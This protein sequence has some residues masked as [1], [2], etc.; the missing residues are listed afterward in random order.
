MKTNLNY[1]AVQ[2]LE[3]LAS[4]VDA[5]LP[6]LRALKVMH[7][8]TND[9]V[10][11]LQLNSIEKGSTYSE[12]LEKHPFSGL[13][14]QQNELLCILIKAGELGGVIEVVL[15]RAVEYLNKERTSQQAQFLDIL[16]LLI[17]RGVPILRS[18]SSLPEYTP[19]FA[20]LKKA[21]HD[22]VR[23]GE[24][25]TRPFK[26]SGMYPAYAIALLDV[27]EQTGCLPEMLRRLSDLM[28]KIQPKQSWLHRLWNKLTT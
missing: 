14:Q 9:D 13:N 8:V 18:L 4:M 21:V 22:S 6:L 17:S 28:E 3:L 2:Q 11:T 1:T 12:A 7:L 16:G 5:G 10:W 23:D 27:G 25:L 19:A 26:E 15:F 20:A 24:T